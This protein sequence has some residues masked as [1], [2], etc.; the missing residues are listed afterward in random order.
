M[1]REA[2]EL[3]RKFLANPHQDKSFIERLKN[4]KSIDLRNN[5]IT[6]DL[7]NGYE[8]IIPIDTNKKF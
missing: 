1:F 8:D 3:S 4:N 7:G 6:V 2:N 5:M